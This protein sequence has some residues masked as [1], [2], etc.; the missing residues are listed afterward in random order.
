MENNK[1][2]A[3][4]S[5]KNFAPANKHFGGIKSMLPVIIKYKIMDYCART[6]IYYDT[7]AGYIMWHHVVNGEK[8]IHRIFLEWHKM[9]NGKEL[10]VARNT[11]AGLRIN[12]SHIFQVEELLHR[13][14]DDKTH[15]PG[16][17]LKPGNALLSL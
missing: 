1:T 13:F 11:K 5:G 17:E 4:N 10:I 3:F 12:F 2:R 9:N 15:R 14:K 8:Q 6:G 7:K 16:M